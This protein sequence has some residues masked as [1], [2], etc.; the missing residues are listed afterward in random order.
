MVADGVGGDT[1]DVGE[2]AA[3]GGVQPAPA[4]TNAN[5]TKQASTYFAFI[6]LIISIFLSVIRRHCAYS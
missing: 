2:L 6:N 3:M 5:V 1:V 4:K